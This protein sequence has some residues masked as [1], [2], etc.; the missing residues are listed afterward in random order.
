MDNRVSIYKF[1]HVWYLKS[2]HIHLFIETV[3]KILIGVAKQ[4]YKSGNISIQTKSMT[5][6][7]SVSRW[8]TGRQWEWRSLKC[9]HRFT[10][11]NVVFNEHVINWCYLTT[12]WK[13]FEIDTAQQEQ[14]TRSC[15]DTNWGCVLWSWKVLWQLITTTHVWRKTR[16]WT[17]VSNCTVKIHLTVKR[18]I[19]VLFLIDPTTTTTM[20]TTSS[21]VST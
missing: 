18:C 21:D 4:Y 6:W 8:N 2:V 1:S 10:R 5:I 3:D 14:K 16:F 11:A 12:E 9:T 17:F 20:T 7:P 19:A 15:F 13:L